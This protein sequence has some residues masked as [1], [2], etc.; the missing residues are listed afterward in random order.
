MRWGK[1]KGHGWET[2]FPLEEDKSI[3]YERVG[4]RVREGVCRAEKDAKLLVV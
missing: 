1:K 2:T 3:F 4:G